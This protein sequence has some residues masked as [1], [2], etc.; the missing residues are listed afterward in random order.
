MQ[1]S[2]K[3]VYAGLAANVAITATKLIVALMSGS[4]SM[5][6]EFFHSAVDTGNSVVLLFGISRSLRPAHRRHPFGHGKELYFWSLVVAISMFTAG[7]VLSVWE[8]VSHLHHGEPVRDPMWSYVVLLVSTAISSVGFLVALREIKRKKGTAGIFQ[9][10]RRSKDPTV[11]TVLFDNG[12]DIAGQLIA[13]LAIFLSVR[14]H[15]PAIDGVGSI[16]VGLVILGVSAVLANES[17]DLL[18]GETAPSEDVM[19]MKKRLQ[20]DPAVE[21]VGDLLTMQLGPNEVLLNVEIQFQRESCVED[22]ERTIGRLERRVREEFPEV[23]HLFVEV[24]SLHD[25][26]EDLQKAS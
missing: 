14:L 18:I 11:F 12:S 7:G 21:R 24:A 26:P 25:R 16:L 15:S 4:S 1:R 23:K 3:V 20:S 2:G 17:R 9:F 10:I 8:G 6:A 19:R 5:L 13:V 22:L